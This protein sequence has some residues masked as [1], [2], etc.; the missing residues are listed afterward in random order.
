MIPTHSSDKTN[1]RE[2]IVNRL[3]ALNEYD[4][5][6]AHRHNYFEFFCF[7]NGDGNHIVDFKKFPIESYS[8]HIVGAGQVHQVNREL[9]SNGF[10]YLFELD[11]INGPP[12]IIEFLFDH[13][14]YDVDEVSPIYRVDKK[15]Q[16]SFVMLTEMIWEAHS[17][18]GSLKNLTIQNAIQSLCIKCMDSVQ[19]RD[20][21]PKSEYAEFRKLLFNEF[22]TIKKVKDYADQLNITEKSLNELVKAQTGKNTSQ[23]IYNQIILEAKRLIQT[24]MSAKEVA[25]DLNFDDPG[26]FSKFFKTKTGYSP[27]EF[28]NVHA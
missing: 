5:S 6:E 15:D 14:C 9:N 23:V 12:E 20:D 13:V 18:S 8:I 4:F 7:I 11:A 24:G 3:S 21:K 27:T 1:R 26:H 22:R 16:V 2:I 28:R 19:N 25:Y 17:G 10:V